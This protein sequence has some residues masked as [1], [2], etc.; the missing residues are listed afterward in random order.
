MKNKNKEK[1]YW[2][3]QGIFSL[4]EII[5]R[6]KKYIRRNNGNIYR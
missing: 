4:K 3:G 2:R 6:Y 5:K 1:W